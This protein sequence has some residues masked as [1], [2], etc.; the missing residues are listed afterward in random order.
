[1]PKRC[2]KKAMKINRDNAVLECAELIRTGST[3]S[4]Y[5]HVCDVARWAKAIVSGKGQDEIVK[6]FRPGESKEQKE[7]LVNLYNPITPMASGMIQ[8]VYRRLRRTDGVTELVEVKDDPKGTERVKEQVG[9]WYGGKDLKE[10]LYDRKEYWTFN[11]PNAWIS[12]EY[13]IK[14][15]LTSGTAKAINVFP[16]E[17]TCHE[18]IDFQYRNGILQWVLFDRKWQSEKGRKL[19]N[20]YLYYVGGIVHF[21]ELDTD[22]EKPDPLSGDETY[23]QIT[24]ETVEESQRVF[25]YKDT[26]IDTERNRATEIFVSRVGE[27]EDPTTDGRT[28]ITPNHF[29]YGNYTDLI[30]DKAYQDLSKTL[31]TF[32]QKYVFGPDCEFEDA[33][34]HRCDQGYIGDKECPRCKGYGA[35]VPTTPQG[36][37]VLKMPE[38]KTDDLF[39]PLSGMAHY[40]E[41]PDWLPKWMGEEIIQAVKWVYMAVFNQELKQELST[42]KTATEVVIDSDSIND[43]IDPYG[44]SFS[45][46]FELS[47]RAAALFEETKPGSIIAYHAFPPN[48]NMETVSELLSKL[49]RVKASGADMSIQMEIQRQIRQKLYRNAPDKVKRI[50]AYEKFLPFRDKDQGVVAMILPGLT[51]YDS[52]KIAFEHFARI[53]REI[54]QETKGEFYLMAYEGQRALFDKWVKLIIEEKKANEP[55]PQMAPIFERNPVVN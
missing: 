55:G 26:P 36:A 22:S 42:A 14:D 48:K 19:S 8:S 44:Q 6:G 45:S 54:E 4:D 39:I 20:Y 41:L 32:L 53:Q 21:H 24:I 17:Y 37:I 18:A 40:V 43:T 5:N 52:D 3:H 7:Q 33:D 38:S 25:L 27:Y 12:A 13:E 2:S 10:Y 16:V 50:E 30:R 49:E 47:V 46:L 11:D 51:K 35:L 28:Y 31:H 15:R 1:M 9:T 23:F 34:G 29:A